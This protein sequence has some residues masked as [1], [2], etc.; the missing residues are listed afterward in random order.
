MAHA[1]SWI[2]ISRF[3]SAPSAERV[4]ARLERAGIE[5]RREPE[6]ATE[7]D[8]FR[9]R[10]PL[11]RV[12]AAFQALPSGPDDEHT[13]PPPTRPSGIARFFQAIRK[14]A[15]GG[16]DPYEGD[17]DLSA[18]LSWVRRDPTSAEARIALARA[19]MADAEEEAGGRARS[20]KL[21]GARRALDEAAYLGAGQ[22]AA[23]ELAELC[24][25][26]GRLS[27]AA[28]W[29]SEARSTGSD[30]PRACY[31]E[32]ELAF[33]R[34]DVKGLRQAVSQYRR[35]L[36]SPDFNL[37]YCAAML[38]AAGEKGAATRLADAALRKGEFGTDEDWTAATAL[39][40][41]ME[42]SD[43]AAVEEL[44]ELVGDSAAEEAVAE[45]EAELQQL[46]EAWRRSVKGS[47]SAGNRQGH[48]PGRHSGP[49]DR[50][51]ASRISGSTGRNRSRRREK[52]AQ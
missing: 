27:E 49:Q 9:I 12:E 46:R 33:Y 52:E 34:G 15:R 36:E 23:F 7:E 26:E 16:V 47:P 6:G 10:V 50:E 13:W 37:V 29:I 28:A 3:L 51:R 41:A 48:R 30:P 19:L 42:G 45:A 43:R 11:E 2:T 24:L 32:C 31:L 22:E 38:F 20:S 35:A 1:P 25:M 4:Q 18:S 39:K 5:V 17:P 14:F 8:L 40:V 21:Q 44:A